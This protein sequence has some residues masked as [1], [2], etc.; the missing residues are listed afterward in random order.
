ML[1]LICNN[2]GYR[3]G[4]DNVLQTHP[5]GYAAQLNDLTGGWFDPTP[6]FSGEASASGG[7]GE[8]VTEPDQ[9]GPAIRRGLTAVQKGGVPA[10]LDIWLPK[11]G[12][13]EI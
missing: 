5:E 6:N 13:G 10:L 2:R 8:K 3:T 11:L 12:T 4:T 1:F 9:L 7:Y